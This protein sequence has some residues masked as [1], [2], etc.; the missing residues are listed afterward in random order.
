MNTTSTQIADRQSSSPYVES[1]VLRTVRHPKLV[2]IAQVAPAA[3]FP[4]KFKI[5]HYRASGDGAAIPSPPPGPQWLRTPGAQEVWGGVVEDALLHENRVYLDH[6]IG[7]NPNPHHPDGHHLNIDGYRQ[8][9]AAARPIDQDAVILRGPRDNNFYHFMVE[10]LPKVLAAGR[11]APVTSRTVFVSRSMPFHVQ[12]LRLVGIDGERCAFVN[13]AL[14][15]R[16]RRATV[17]DDFGIWW[18]PHPEVKLIAGA[19]R[20]SPRVDHCRRLYLDRRAA[21]KRRMVNQLDVAARLAEFGFKAVVLEHL[22]LDE[23]I[24]TVAQAEMIVAPH[25]A[26]LTHVMFARPGLKVLEIFPEGWSPQ[27]FVR[28][29]SACDL[30]GHWWTLTVPARHVG[31]NPFA[32]CEYEVDIDALAEIV[33]ALLRA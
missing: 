17:I 25:G 27:L 33:D 21:S 1:R 10:K 30:F 29:A 18:K 5:G 23:Q 24:E 32:D 9:L 14:P 26:G 15:L 4:T 2:H 6:E 20:S 8:L 22:P 31:P 19:L 11:L 12:S 7:L 28:L 13:P 16:L 3:T